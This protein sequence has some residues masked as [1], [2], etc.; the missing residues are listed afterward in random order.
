[1]HTAHNVDLAPHTTFGVR[2]LCDTLVTVRSTQELAEALESY[3]EA[4]IL[5][6]GSNILCT[7]DVHG[8]VIHLR[9]MGVTKT[10]TLVT[11]QAGES[12][13]GLVTWCVERGLG[14]LENLALIPGTVG[15]APMQ[16][17]GA[18]GVEQDACC[19][20]V[21][22]MDRRTR[23]LI[24]LLPTDCAFGY[25]TSRFKQEWRN[26][27]VITEV[28]YRLS[29]AP[30]YHVYTDYRDVAEELAARHCSQPS[31]RDVYEAVVAIRQRKLPDPASIGN[32]GSFFKNPVVLAS[33]AAALRD[34]HPQMPTY[35]Q[36]D[37]TVKIAAAW[38]ID[39]CGWKGYREHD[40]GV[41]DRQA[42]VLVN[43][44]SAVGAEILD[45]ANRIQQSVVERFGIPLETEVNVW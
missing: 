21:T 25:R 19:A 29:N 9:L 20:G 22:V 4:R 17:I 13:H 24:M 10:D 36:S 23:E 40:A 34:V 32:A 15:A 26:R 39:Q 11:A 37:G 45:L 3:P 18:Y 38:L 35:P 1:M 14:G 2:A 16:N 28:Q 33:Q 31:L 30:D 43:H 41:H 12:W 6:G 8:P 5:G 7:S 44:G 27:Y 42:L